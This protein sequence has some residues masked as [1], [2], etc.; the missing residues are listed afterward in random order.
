MTFQYPSRASTT[1][2]TLPSD[3]ILRSRTKTALLSPQGPSGSYERIAAPE[4]IRRPVDLLGLLEIAHQ[5]GMAET[6]QVALVEA[7]RPDGT[8]RRFA[9]GGVTVRTKEETHE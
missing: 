7:I 6:D 1:V 5:D 9:F 8:R 3:P 2:E 4:R